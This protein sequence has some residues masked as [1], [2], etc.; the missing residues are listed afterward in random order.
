[1]DTLLNHEAAHV[2][3]CFIAPAGVMR[4]LAEWARGSPASCF[5]SAL[6]IIQATAWNERE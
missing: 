5:L 1:M 4:K 2:S 3:L 6:M